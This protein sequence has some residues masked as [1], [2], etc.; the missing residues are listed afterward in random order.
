MKVLTSTLGF[1]GPEALTAI[2]NKVGLQ[3]V[4]YRRFMFDTITIYWESQFMNAARI[5]RLRPEI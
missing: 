1:M 2:M 4:Q 3:E 5:K